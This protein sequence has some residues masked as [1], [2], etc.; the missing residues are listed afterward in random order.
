MRGGLGQVRAAGM[1]NS[2]VACEIPEILKP[3][4]SVNGKHPENTT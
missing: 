1:Y 4:F 2:I 3:E